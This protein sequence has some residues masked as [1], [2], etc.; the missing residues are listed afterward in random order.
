MMPAIK[1]GTRREADVQSTGPLRVVRFATSQARYP[2]ST[3]PS[4]DTTASPG[5][6]GGPGMLLRASQTPSTP[7][8]GLYFLAVMLTRIQNQGPPC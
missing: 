5:R 7:L 4:P 8:P 2:V 1:R 6:W 3:G